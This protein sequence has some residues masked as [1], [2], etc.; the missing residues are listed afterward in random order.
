MDLE[1]D[2]EEQ[3]WTNYTSNRECIYEANTHL[4]LVFEGIIFLAI[5]VSLPFIP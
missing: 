2:V 5:C 1:E 3:N 4:G